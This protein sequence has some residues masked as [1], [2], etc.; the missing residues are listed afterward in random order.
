MSGVSLGGLGRLDA[1]WSLLACVSTPLSQLMYLRINN[2]AF[3]PLLQG[4]HAR[5]R[6][7]VS[8]VLMRR[9]EQADWRWSTCEVYC[10]VR[11]LLDS[12]LWQAAARTEFEVADS[13]MMY[14]CRTLQT[15]RDGCLNIHGVVFGSA[16]HIATG[17]SGVSM[18]CISG[19]HFWRVSMDHMCG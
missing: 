2:G 5:A 4:I 6:V 18:A 3:R 1:S 14:I 19:A 16:M 11:S 15:R 7:I 13:F 9:C 12:H 8:K 17:P 10:C